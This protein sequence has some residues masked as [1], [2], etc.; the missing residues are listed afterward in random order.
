[1]ATNSATIASI[2][3]SVAP[4]QR[5]RLEFILEPLQGILQIAF[6]SVCPIGSKVTIR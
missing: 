1:M 2:I 4:R 5:E 3:Q 6:L